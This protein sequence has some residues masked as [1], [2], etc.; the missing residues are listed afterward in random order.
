[1]YGGNRLVDDLKKICMSA[2]NANFPVFAVP[3]S[4]PL[5]SLSLPHLLMPPKN[6]FLGHK[7]PY[8]WNVTDAFQLLE[9]ANPQMPHQELLKQLK[10]NLVHA[11]D[12]G[13]KAQSSEANKLLKTWK[14]YQVILAKCKL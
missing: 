8:D 2:N 10:K 14:V 6:Y 1:M 12:V 9:E 11:R 5:L 3:Q 4:L 7:K 13:T